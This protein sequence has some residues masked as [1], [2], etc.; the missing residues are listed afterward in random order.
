MNKNFIA[1]TETDGTRTLIN[2]D[3]A[4]QVTYSPE[5]ERCRLWFDGNHFADFAGAA[6]A[7]LF[8]HLKDRATSLDQ[9]IRIE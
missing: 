9:P 2:I 4:R 3:M 8:T 1:F 5:G 6:A 7:A